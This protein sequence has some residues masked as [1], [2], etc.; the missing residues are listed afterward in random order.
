VKQI[1]GRGLM[2]TR[3]LCLLSRAMLESKKKGATGKKNKVFHRS[4]HIHNITTNCQLKSAVLTSFLLSFQ[5]YI[6]IKK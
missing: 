5:G 4:D 3:P 1:K 2:S 6:Y